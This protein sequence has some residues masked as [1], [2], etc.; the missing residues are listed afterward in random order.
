MY[1]RNTSQLHH[2][3]SKRNIDIYYLPSIGSSR[4]AMFPDLSGWSSLSCF[5]LPAD[6]SVELPVVAL[7]WPVI[8]GFVGVATTS[9]IRG[10]AGGSSIPWVRSSSSSPPRDFLGA[11]ADEADE[12]L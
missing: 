4:S 7:L 5:L 11:A 2:I 9:T 1:L 10:S 8:G 12:A 6:A 3:V